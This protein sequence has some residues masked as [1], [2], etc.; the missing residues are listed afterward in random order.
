MSLVSSFKE[1]SLA[2]KIS[3]TALLAI[4]SL[5]MINAGIIGH[6]ITYNEL[7]E[8]GRSSPALDILIAPVITGGQWYFSEEASGSAIGETPVSLLANQTKKILPKSI[9]TG[10]G[11]IF[12]AAGTPGAWIGQTIGVV[13]GL[14]TKIKHDF[15]H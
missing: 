6:T 4:N 11:I 3:V 10:V 14:S 2:K 13:S 5:T 8:Q 7:S 12:A 9:D 15:S 1:A